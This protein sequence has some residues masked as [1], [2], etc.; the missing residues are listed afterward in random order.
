MKSINIQGCG[1]SRLAAYEFIPGDC[2]YILVVCHGFRGAK[3][4]SGNIFGF[5]KRVNQL[6]IG[7]LAFDFTGSGSSG[8]EFADVTLTQ[9]VADLEQV[10]NYI[11]EQYHKQVILLGRSFGGSTV[12]ALAD[13]SDERV[14]GYIFWSAPVKLYETFAGLAAQFDQME[15]CEAVEIKYDSGSFR[16]KHGFFNDFATHDLILCAQKLASQPVLIIHGAADEVVKPTNAIKL[17]Q[18]CNNA[19]LHIIAGAD[20][21]FTRNIAEREDITL[22]WLQKFL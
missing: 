13:K 6:G 1:Q 17:Y 4:N 18:K 21:R 8:G 22:R 16:L 20:H 10:I 2:R 11:E 5:A 19:E 7:M 12:L 15:G 9:Q 3:E 14:A